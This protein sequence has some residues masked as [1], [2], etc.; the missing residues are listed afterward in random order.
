MIHMLRGK[1]I[2]LFFLLIIS[3]AAAQTEKSDSVGFFKKIENMILVKDKGKEGSEVRD[4]DKSLINKYAGKIIRHIDIKILDV[5]G[6]SIYNPD[7][8]AKTWF[9]DKGNS[10]HVNTKAWLIKYKLIFSEGDKLVPYDIQESERIIRQT[11]YVKDVRILPEPA[12]EGSDSVDIT[13]YSQDIW[14]A[15]GDLLYHPASK[16]GRAAFTDNNF[17]GYGNAFKAGLKFDRSFEHGWDWDGGYSINNIKNTFL[18]ADINYTSNVNQK[19]YALS[20]GRDFFS[21]VIKWAG[22]AAQIWQTTRYAVVQDSNVHFDDAGYNQQDYWLGYAFDF[23]PF[24]PTTIYQNRFNISARVTRTV[25]SQKPAFDTTSLFQNNTFILGRLGYAYRK[26]YQ[27]QY[28]FGLGKTEDIPVL[29]TLELLFGYEIGE[30]TKRPYYGLKSGY[31]TYNYNS[32][33]IYGGFQIG[34]FR[35]KSS[36]VNGAGILQM[37]YFSKLLSLGSWSWRHYIGAMYAFSL[38]QQMTG[39]ALDLNNSN[40]IRGFFDNEVKGNKKLVFN[41]E[42]DIFLPV[43]IFGFNMAILTFADLGILTSDDKSFLDNRLYQGY[44]VGFRVKNENLIFPTFQFMIGI[45]P[46]IAGRHFSVFNQ[47]SIFN[48]LNQYQAS[49]PSVV[50]GQ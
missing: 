46:N 24:D 34:A 22:A 35:N 16:S 15:N 45:Y 39:G 12:G 21:P 18:T 32:G 37:L 29:N 11:P 5:F 27:D 41:Y 42:A 40:G 26:F 14:S 25:Y 50:Q 2:F 13:V 33:Y 19:Q 44:G 36:W 28:V 20:I 49:I 17:L 48:Q 10:L 47:G 9:G 43:K 23:K 6:P 38:D 7:D 3:P 1:K 30:S 8:T 4:S 31:S